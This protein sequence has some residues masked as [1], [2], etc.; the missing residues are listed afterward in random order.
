VDGARRGEAVGVA[1]ARAVRVAALSFRI[2]TPATSS[3][4]QV[5]RDTRDEANEALSVNLSS[6]SNTTISDGRRA[7]VGRA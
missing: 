6:A 1:S 3:V 5:C 2:R 4:V 7:V